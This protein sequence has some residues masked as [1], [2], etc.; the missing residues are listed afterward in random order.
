VPLVPLASQGA[1]Q[2]VHPHIDALNQ[3]LR[4]ERIA[5][6]QEDYP[7]LRF[8]PMGA[9]DPLP[10][11]FLTLYVLWMGFPATTNWTEHPR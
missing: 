9:L 6:T 8:L 11:H 3:L 2:R 1:S 5:V 10:N 7:R 4:R